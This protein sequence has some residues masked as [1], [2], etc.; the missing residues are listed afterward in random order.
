METSSNRHSSIISIGSQERF[1]VDLDPAQEQMKKVKKKIGKKRKPLGSPFENAIP[2]YET[3][4]WTDRNSWSEGSSLLGEKLEQQ[5]TYMEL[6]NRATQCDWRWARAAAIWGNARLL[7][8]TIA[9]KPPRRPTQIVKDAVTE[10]E[11]EEGA[12]NK[13]SQTHIEPRDE[14]KHKDR[15]DSKAKLDGTE[16]A[17]ESAVPIVSLTNVSDEGGEPPMIAIIDDEGT[18]QEV[19]HPH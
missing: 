14:D 5:L 4:E 7:R 9:T 8:P 1:L 16:R 12:L 2:P 3:M 11:H 10:T 6:V 18:V 19:S 15:Q 13:A 17:K